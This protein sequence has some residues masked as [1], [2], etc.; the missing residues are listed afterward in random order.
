MFRLLFVACCLASSVFA[1]QTMRHQHVLFLIPDAMTPSA[2]WHNIPTQVQEAG[3]AVVLLD[4]HLWTVESYVYRSDLRAAVVGLQDKGRV[5]GLHF[6]PPTY[7]PPV[8]HVAWLDKAIA[9]SADLG[10]SPAVRYVYADGAE[11]FVEGSRSYVE[12]L[13]RAY[14]S[15]DLVQ[16][17][18]PRLTL[19]LLTSTPSLDVPSARECV[20]MSEATYNLRLRLHLLER[21]ADAL[22]MKG[23]SLLMGSGYRIEIGW[24]GGVTARLDEPM[25][26]PWSAY[27]GDVFARARSVGASVT[28]RLTPDALARI[29][30]AAVRAALTGMGR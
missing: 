5:V 25:R 21:A 2:A 18:S 15:L 3:F 30:R 11:R 19:D 24:L 4:V 20:E 26:L 9:T 8:E 14:P 22:S 27:W 7:I 29:D 10:I 13:R 1:Q 12:R 16:S 6:A 28:V 23:S 17:S